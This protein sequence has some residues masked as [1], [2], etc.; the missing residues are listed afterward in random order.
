MAEARATLTTRRGEIAMPAFL[1][2]ATRAVVRGVTS[3][4]L[5]EVGTP[6]LVVNAFHLLRRPGVRVVQA[7]GGIHAFMGWDR[8]V[9]SDSGGFQV[10]SLIRQNPDYGVIRANE[11]IF[12]EPDTGEKWTLTP[13][14]V[15]Q[16]Q[17]QLGSD[18]VVCLDD[19]TD[20]GAGLDEQE[21]AVERTIRWARRC[22]EEYNRLAGQMKREQPPLIFAVVQGGGSEALRRACAQALVEIGFDGF[23]F[24]G[25][26][27][28]AD[29]AL[30]TDVL[31]WVADALPPDAP[32]HALGIGSPAH[33]VTARALGYT[34]F[35][36]SFPTRDARHNRLYVFQ[37]GFP[38]R[39]P[40]PGERF[41][42]TLYILDADYRADREPVDPGCDCPLCRTYSRAYLHHLFK[43][44]DAAGERLAT[45][46]NLRFYARL[47]AALP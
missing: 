10:Y 13:E 29:G 31:G 7:H 3:S 45:L 2:D 6:A 41:Y 44:G 27:L 38:E 4:D 9:L 12:R 40:R 35:D 19:C 36:S 43:I 46:H 15:I 16:I 14:R 18:I 20:V 24:G 28:D 11:V 21:R 33:V 23:G 5:V 30:L 1:P 17:F 34:T 39:A 22:R 32:K 25:W 47:L 26:P 42:R 8:P 37:L